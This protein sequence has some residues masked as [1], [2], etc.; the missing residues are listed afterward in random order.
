MEATLRRI[1][2]FGPILFAVGFIAPLIAQIAT[3]AGWAPPFGLS[4][5]L[6]GLIIA[7]VLGGVAQIRGRWL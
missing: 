3:R 2:Y 1:F 5:A 6:F 7:G 4:P